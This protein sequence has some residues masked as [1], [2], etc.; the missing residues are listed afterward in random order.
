VTEDIYPINAYATTALVIVM[1][2]ITDYVLYKPIVMLDALSSIVMYLLILEP[3]TLFK[4]KVSSV[5]DFES[6]TQIGAYLLFCMYRAVFN[7]LLQMKNNKK[8]FE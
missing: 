1:F 2:L 4:S 6:I 8:T 7:Q 3:V 5:S